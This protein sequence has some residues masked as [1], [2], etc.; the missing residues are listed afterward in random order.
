MLGE[1]RI[2]AQ[3]LQFSSP[4]NDGKCYIPLV[5]WTNYNLVIM[6]NDKGIIQFI[7]KKKLKMYVHV[8]IKYTFANLNLQQA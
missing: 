5:S 7:E 1:L 3:I 2:A 6:R 8:P 4:G